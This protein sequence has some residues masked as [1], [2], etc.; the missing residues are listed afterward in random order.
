[1]QKE[2]YIIEWIDTEVGKIPRI[3]TFLDKRDRWGTFKVRLNINRMNYKVDP[4]IYAVGNPDSDSV[5]LVS[6]NYKLSFDYLRKKLEGLDAWIMVLD[7]RG[8]N[9]WCAAGKGTFGTDELVKRIEV[10]ELKR[11][12][13]HRKLI[14]PQLGAPGIAAHNVKK[15]SGFLVI[16]GP[17]RSSDLKDFL[18]SGMKATAMMRQVEFRLIDRL[19]LVPVEVVQG[20]RYL[21]LVI[22]FF[23]ILSG[24]NKNGYSFALIGTIGIR[25]VANILFAFSAGAVIGPLFLPWLPARSFFLKGFY[26]GI[27]VSLISYLFNLIG[28]NIL[29]IL[30]WLLLIS[31]ISSFLTMNFTGCSTYTSLSGVKR[32]MRIGIPIQI[33]LVV[34]GSVLW[35][36]DR[37]V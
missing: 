33:I 8:I 36:V 24:L 19:R 12:V 27:A 2:H 3:S 34:T 26:S 29:E 32:E 22:I 11:L 10:T 25:S 30:T 31:S 17:V 6:A 5:V 4:G 28:H 20:S 9:V 23:L 1:M 14:V 7:T 16:Y 21:F 35:I 37:F 15:R 18:K 13:R